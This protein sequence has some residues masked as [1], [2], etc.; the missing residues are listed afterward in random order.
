MT[1][2]VNCDEPI[3]RTEASDRVDPRDY[4][5]VHEGGNPICDMTLVASPGGDG[6]GPA[7]PQPLLNSGGARWLTA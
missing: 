2:C 6:N 5:W 4:G 1:S 3:R 7:S